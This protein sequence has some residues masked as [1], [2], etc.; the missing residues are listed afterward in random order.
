MNT[1][2]MKAPIKYHL[3]SFRKTIQIMYLCVYL[4]MLLTVISNIFKTPFSFESNSMMEFVSAITIFVIG[5]VSF[6]E[7]FKFSLAN[8]ISRKTQFFSTTAALGI[9]STVLAFIDTINCL[10]FT[11]ITH[12]CPLFLQI[13]G[14][15]SS[16]SDSSPILTPQMLFENFLWLVFLYFLVSMIGLFITTLYYRMNRGFKIAVSIFVPVVLINGF[17]PLDSYFFAGKLTAVLQNFLSVAFGLSNGCNPYIAMVSMFVFAFFFAAL[18]YLLAR[19][20]SIKN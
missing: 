12:Y 9:L 20:A 1:I 11:H 4:V 7:Y 14:I 16:F 5:L 17:E 15:G 8:G 10:I 6:K 3:R 18:T 2:K 19:K 13:Y